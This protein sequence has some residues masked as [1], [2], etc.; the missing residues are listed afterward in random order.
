MPLAWLGRAEI[1][2]REPEVAADLGLW[3]PN[4]GIVDSHG[5]RQEKDEIK[6]AMHKHIR[7][8]HNYSVKTKGSSFLPEVQAALELLQELRILLQKDNFL[9]DLELQKR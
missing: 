8:Q 3:S 1:Q 6:L 4:T 5:V 9:Q 2:A 7:K